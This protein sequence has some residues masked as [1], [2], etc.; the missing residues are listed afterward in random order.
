MTPS[1]SL[2]TIH[3]MGRIA[4]TYYRDLE[5][6]LL[7]RLHPGASAL[8]V[9]PVYFKHLLEPH[10]KRVWNAVSSQVRWRGL[11]QFGLYSLGDVAG[12]VARKSKPD[13]PYTRSQVVIARVL[14]LARAAMGGN[15]PVVLVAH[16]LGCQVLSNY[17]W[18]A[19]R[20]FRCGAARVG[21]WQ[22][23]LQY[24][25]AI[26]GKTTLTAEELAFLGGRS[27]RYVYT[28]GCNIPI[29][30]AGEPETYIK[31]I[32]KPTDDFEWHNFFDRDDVL[33]WPLA[34]LSDSYRT[35]V[36]D[37]AVN[38][39]RGLRGWLW[40]SWNPLS[41]DQYWY[42]DDFLSHLQASLERLLR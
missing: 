9:H 1:A 3:G 6:A 7:R 5:R 40:K 31:A 37:H 35:L 18:D 41:H 32:E 42:T 34:P 27:I 26:A 11:R 19:Q 39:Y 38:A 2:V 25:E 15:G 13:S 16:S 8:K 33:G 23:P 30:V 21:M 29:F 24:A 28:T 12:L 22:D 4:T 14:H 20:F 10:Q 36:S 17:L